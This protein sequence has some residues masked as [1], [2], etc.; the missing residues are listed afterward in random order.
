VSDF[1][2]EAVAAARTRVRAAAAARPLDVLR[3]AA[4]DLPSPPPFA[5]ALAGDGLAVI[6]EVKRAS[7][8]RGALAQIPD[9]AALGRAYAAGGAAAISVLTEPVWFRGSMKDLSAVAAA[10]GLPV[11]RKDFIVD[12]YQVWEA[13]AAG[14]AAVLLILAALD[15]AALAELRA[16][17]GEA[18][19]DTLIE[20]H[21]AEEAGRVRP[22]GRPLVVGVN[23]RD[24]ATLSVD[25]GGIDTVRRALPPEALT[26][27]ESGIRG[28]DDLAGLRGRWHAVLVGEHVATAADPRAAVAA[29]AAVNLERTAP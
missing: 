6:A 16:T 7:P 15:D 3:A 18:G 25:T 19:L 4:A 9:P 22:D 11:L 12:P 20:V 10:V 24:L 13:R 23:A 28:P 2:A 1:L 27:A 17:A 14:A 26:V 21:D 29:L 5:A 8:S